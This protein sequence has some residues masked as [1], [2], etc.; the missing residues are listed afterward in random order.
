[1]VD[2]VDLKYAMMLSNKLEKWKVKS[3]NPYRINFRCPICGDSAKS[4]SKS[5]G[6]LL[7]YKNR[8]AYYCHNCGAPDH[9]SFYKFLK[10]VDI[11][12]YKDYVTDK[13]IEDKPENEQQTTKEKE[14][15]KVEFKYNPLKDIKKISSLRFDHPAKQY[16]QKRKIPSDQHYRIFYAPKFKKWINSYIPNKFNFKKDEPRLI[17]PLHNKEGK[18][19]GVSS[20]G[21]DPNGLR[22]ITI[23]FDES[24]YKIFGLDLVDFDNQ[25]YIVEG[26]IDSLFLRNS[27]AMVGADVNL[28]GLQNLENS[29]I[30][31]DNEPRNKEI[32]RKM[33][34]LIK[35][36]MRICIWPNYLSER[37]KDLND[38]FLSGMN[39][40][41]IRQV[42]DDNT[43]QGLEAEIKFQE[44]K[45]L[46]L[47]K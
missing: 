20:R 36:K 25:Y 27:I 30:V 22:Y 6:W 14:L 47:T 29:T 42:I 44:W 45:K 32:C 13:F 16:I 3:Q 35:K 18:I 41:Q 33:Y 37:G 10:H 43:F 1:M 26:A 7:E 46:H 12:L 39:R 5:R 15:Y 31:F 11:G 23:M 17:F 34:D 19:I 40:K 4:K 21:F 9:R 28:E 38:L 24:Q 2:H 8:F